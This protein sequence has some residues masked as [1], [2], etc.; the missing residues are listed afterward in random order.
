M[1]KKTTFSCVKD[2]DEQR[3]HLGEQQARRMVTEWNLDSFSLGDEKP[4]FPEQPG[5]IL[6][7]CQGEY[8]AALYDNDLGIA[9]YSL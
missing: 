2:Y 4:I 3:K 5:V 6:P 8:Y 9:R 7:L 1:N